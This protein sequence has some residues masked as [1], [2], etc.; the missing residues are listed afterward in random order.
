MNGGGGALLGRGMRN[1]KD[2]VATAN[3]QVRRKNKLEAP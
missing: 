2:R 3:G 1:P